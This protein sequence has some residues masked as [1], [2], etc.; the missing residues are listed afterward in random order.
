MRDYERKHFKEKYKIFF[1]LVF[2][3]YILCLALLSILQIMD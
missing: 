1:F 2:G 3:L